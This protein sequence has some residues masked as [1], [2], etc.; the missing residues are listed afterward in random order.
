MKTLGVE[1]EIINIEKPVRLAL[2]GC[3]SHAYRN[4]LPSLRFVPDATLTVVCD[5]NEEKAKLFAK[6]H[7]A[8]TYFSSTEEL[9]NHYKESYDA[10]IAIVGFCPVTG[11]P[12]YPK[13][14]EP[15][16]L[17]GIPVWLEK[18]P[19]ASA[20]ALESITSSAR[21]GNTFFQVG[22]KM[23]FSPSVE[24]VKKLI[25]KESFG[26]VRSFD[27]SYAVT[28]PEDIRDLTNPDARRFLDDIVHILS[29]IQFLFGCPSKMTVFSNG[30]C[31][32]TAIL[33]YEENIV[34]TLRILGGVSVTGPAE[35]MRVIGSHSY[36]DNGCMIEL[37]NAEKV[38][39]HDAGNPGSY[40]RDISFNLW[41]Y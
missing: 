19:A 21:K 38:L 9:L 8:E 3:G 28:L 13:V 16:L 20:K 39:F 7:G 41:V 6:H 34:G 31:D 29:Q 32:A 5:K 4:I 37:Q 11:E 12:L 14:L 15:F 26:K 10:I 27:A 18:P 30:V 40:G 2:L 36:H 17:K 1:G 22:F 23:M 35:Y 25:K 33:E 24:K